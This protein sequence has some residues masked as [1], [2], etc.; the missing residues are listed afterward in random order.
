MDSK[1]KI[2]NIREI[3]KASLQ[4]SLTCLTILVAMF[5]L[6]HSYE[7]EA[8]LMIRE[9]L[10]TSFVCGLFSIFF[11][12]ANLV[13][14]AHIEKINTYLPYSQLFIFLQYFFLML[15]ILQLAR[16]IISI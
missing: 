13:I 14:L 1:G 2:E 3:S 9:Y 10:Y 4:A 6:F 7:P 12:S 11:S 5:G 8:Y 16:S 15:M